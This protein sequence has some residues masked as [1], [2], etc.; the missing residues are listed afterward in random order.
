MQSNNSV[1]NGLIDHSSNFLLAAM[2]LSFV[3]MFG[4]QMFYYADS[5]KD[6]VPNVGFAFGVGICIGLFT[7][8][9]RLS[10]GLAGA[11]EF[12][13]GRYGSGAVGLLFS[14]CITLFE[15]FEVQAIA[16]KWSGRDLH[17]HDSLLLL[18]QF[19]IWTGF[20]LELRLAMNVS[21]SS[22]IENKPVIFSANGTA[23]KKRTAQSSS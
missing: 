10:F 22:S 18:F 8:L 17:L 13:N 9:C 15:A 7:Q 2:V 1:L 6:V 4:V 12:S 3:L 16:I 23:K 20:C 14:F 19:L 21:S 5:F 11:F